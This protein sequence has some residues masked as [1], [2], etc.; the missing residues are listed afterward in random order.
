MPIEQHLVAGERILAIAPGGF[1]ATDQREAQRFGGDYFHPLPHHRRFE[2]D[3]FG[4]DGLGSGCG[5]LIIVS[6]VFK[7]LVFL[8]DYLKGAFKPFIGV[9]QPAPP[10]RGIF[11]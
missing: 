3:E 8:V 5:A 4:Q 9:P 10:D 1:Y 11:P 6:I 2:Q 7:L